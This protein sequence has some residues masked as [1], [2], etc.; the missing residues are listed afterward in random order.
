MRESFSTP[1][2]AGCLACAED[3]ALLRG[4]G[5]PIFQVPL[6][7]IT[8]EQA[9]A[10]LQCGL[11]AAACP[12]GLDPADPLRVKRQELVEVGVVNLGDYRYLCPDE[13]DNMWALCRAALG[14]DYDDIEPREATSTLFFPGCT[15]ATYSPRL[16]R[17][18][19]EFLD[20]IYPGA[21]AVVDC[22]GKP[23]RYMGLND[24]AQQHLKRL[25]AKLE[26]WCVS[27]L[28]VGCPNCY[29]ELLEGLG[30]NAI[31]VVDVYSLL[32]S[33]RSLLPVEDRRPSVPYTVHDPCPDREA[34]VFGKQVR[35]L[36]EYL[37]VPVRE[38]RHHGRYTICCGTGGMAK[39]FVPGAGDWSAQLRAE[40]AR[41]S[42][43]QGMF[44]YC[45]SCL[46][47]LADSCTPLPVVHAL[48]FFLNV[49]DEALDN[50]RKS[51]EALS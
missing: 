30:G 46:F 22:C 4:Y 6:H 26:Q 5:R 50:R 18:F 31:E 7:E 49:Q 51:R 11:C 14:I 10:C 23:L 12:L 42:G 3:C 35:A 48:S 32:Y 15:I 19:L 20:G 39:H 2:C 33:H 40:E 34:G 17:A 44:A 9:F 1:Q 27:R 29:Y 37:E 8:A 25:E 47:N 43:A 36:L 28:V 13:H 38:M 21:K 45:M 24:R 41:A 16:T